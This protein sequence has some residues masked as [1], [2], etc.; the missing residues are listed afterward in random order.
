MKLKSVK[1]GDSTVTS[2]DIHRVLNRFREVFV[3]E[4]EGRT[5]RESASIFLTS[6]GYW[7]STFFKVD[8]DGKG[9]AEFMEQVEVMI[10]IEQK[11][12]EKGDM[13]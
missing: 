5:T 6:L 11:P 13:Q 12:D 4:T 1:D 3:E 9:L 7:L 2:A 8:K 10:A